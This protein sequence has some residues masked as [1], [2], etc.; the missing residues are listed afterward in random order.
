MF[1]GLEHVAISSPDPEALAK[2]YVDHLGFYVNHSYMGNFFVKALNGAV[3]EIIPSK[4]EKRA[5]QAMTTPGLRHM[6]I[7]VEDFD[8]AHQHLR[9][10]GVS[11]LAEPFMVGDNRLVFFTDPEGNLI[12]LIKRKT[13]L[14]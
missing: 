10:T 13:A 14:P 12:H 11:F 1:L 5:E 3:L 8:A 2:W 6:A 7:L 4:G 9:N